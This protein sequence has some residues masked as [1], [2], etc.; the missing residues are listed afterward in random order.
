[1]TGHLQARHD[2]KGIVRT[3]FICPQARF[4]PVVIRDGDDIQI[5]PLRDVLQHLLHGMNTV[6]D[7]RMNVQV[8]APC[9]GMHRVYDL[10]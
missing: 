8:G 9:Q 7:G 3:P 5:A 10:I 4:Q 6:T 1:M 2:L